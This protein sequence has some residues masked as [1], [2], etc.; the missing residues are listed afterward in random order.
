VAVAL[1]NTLRMPLD[2][3]VN[4]LGS[5]RAGT[6]AGF[7]LVDTM[8]VVALVGTA[9]A[10]A[11]P[12]LSQTVGA[13]K[14]STAAKELDRELQAARYKAVSLNRTMRLRLNCPSA[15][16]YRIVELTGVAA[17]DTAAN[18]CN[19]AVYTFPAAADTDPATP[20]AD[21]PLRNIGQSITLVG[22]DLQFEPDGTARQIVAG[23]PQTIGGT[24]TLRVTQSARTMRVSVNGLGRSRVR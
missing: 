8:L 13:W 22:R 18:R 17:T 24:V 6:S 1:L 19:P 3:S 16:D 5:L 9:F 15:G 23:V 21:G 4:S 14:L 10:V 11:V 7:S 12:S 2:S 20:I